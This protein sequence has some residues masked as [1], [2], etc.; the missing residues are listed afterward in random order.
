MNIQIFFRMLA[1]YEDFE[2][3]KERYIEPLTQIFK[4]G[5]EITTVAH[6][7]RLPT[8]KLS[9]YHSLMVQ[10][11]AIDESEVAF[12]RKLMIILGLKPQG[13]Y[14][15]AD[16]R[17]AM[18][19]YCDDSINWSEI[20]FDFGISRRAIYKNI[21]VIANALNFTDLKQLKEEWVRDN[22]KI[23]QAITTCVFKKKGKQP[24]LSQ[25]EELSLAKSCR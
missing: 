21:T 8:R 22:K 7:K 13:L 25:I 3:E 24:Y 10:K 4:N 17:Q 15:D 19:A 11:I 18:L 20:D 14:D 9:H 5:L 16:K 2:F 12:R 1:S 6:N 23:K